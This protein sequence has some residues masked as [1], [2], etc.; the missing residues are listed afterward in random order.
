[1]GKVVAFP[2]LP[3]YFVIFPHHIYF[4][5]RFRD[6]EPFDDRS[7]ENNSFASQMK[8]EAYSARYGQNNTMQIVLHLNLKDF[9]QHKYQ[10]SFETLSQLW[11]RYFKISSFPLELRR[12][13]HGK[14]ESHLLAE[15]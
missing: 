7:M 13:W 6:E 14:T 9:C 10:F 12:F 1:M 4:F 2:W 3:D 8:E 15:S 11:P 5:S